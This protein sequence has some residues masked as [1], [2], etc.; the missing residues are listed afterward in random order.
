MIHRSTKLL[1]VI[2]CADGL[3]YL[4]D[5]D[6]HAGRDARGVG[7]LIDLWFMAICKMNLN[8]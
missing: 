6:T 8:V 5:L 3:R 7:V 1:Y 4:V 2:A